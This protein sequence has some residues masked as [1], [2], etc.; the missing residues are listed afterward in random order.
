MAGA[1]E[2]RRVAF[3]VANEGIEQA[4]RQLYLLCRSR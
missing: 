2:G 3:V 4:E 1:L